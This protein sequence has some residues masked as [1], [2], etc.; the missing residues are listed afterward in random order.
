MQRR[1]KTCFGEDVQVLAQCVCRNVKWHNTVP[2]VCECLKKLKVDLPTSAYKSQV[3]EG[4]VSNKYYLLIE[5][6]IME[7]D[8]IKPC[9]H[10]WINQLITLDIHI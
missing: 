5:L 4:R 7:K 6:L 1:N 2:K 8:E 9:V 10:Q 3:I